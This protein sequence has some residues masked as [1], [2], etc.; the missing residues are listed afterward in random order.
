VI[1]KDPAGKKDGE[2]VRTSSGESE[3]VLRVAMGRN[4][5]HDLP[6]INGSK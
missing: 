5:G 4:E 2:L 3:R 1:K 6:K